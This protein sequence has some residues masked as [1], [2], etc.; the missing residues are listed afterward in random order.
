MIVKVV[1]VDDHT[2]VRSGLR[3]LLESHKSIEIVAEA[4]TGE[5]AYQ[6]YGEVLPD[7]VLMDIS[8]PGMGGLEAAK[9]ILQRYPQ[10]KIV[11]FSMHEAVSFAAQAL[12]TGVKGY[13]TKTGVADDLVQAVLD[14]AKG[15]TFLSQDVAQKVAL[16]TLI[17]ESNPLQQLTSREFEVFRLLAEGKRVEDVAEM[18][19]ISQK[20][21]A[22][23]YTLIKQKLSVNSP[24]EM[25][26]LAMKHGLID[27]E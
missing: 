26:R 13:V 22:N 27:A 6:V 20:T 9:R 5:M 7:V 18:L 24:V 19:K 11:I 17:G 2:V 12:K 10:A 23:Y 21:V 14:V 15:R 16:Q 8:M 1:L 25:V 3:R 4:D